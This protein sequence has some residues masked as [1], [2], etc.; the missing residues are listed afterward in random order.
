[1]NAPSST[2]RLPTIR[3]PLFLW[4]MRPLRLPNIVMI[5]VCSMYVI[6]CR[7]PLLPPG[8]RKM[9][10]AVILHSTIIA[11]RLGRFSSRERGFLHAQGFTRDQMWWHT[12]LASSVSAVV[13]CA[14]IALLMM[15]GVRSVVQD[16]LFQ[17]PY[18]PFMASAEYSTS[19]VM[20]L[21][22]IIVLPAV[23]YV[24]IRA[25]QPVGDA[26]AGWMLTSMTLIFAVWGFEMVLAHRATPG[27][28]QN[29]IPACLPAA[30]LY[31]AGCWRLHRTMEVRS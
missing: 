2:R 1:M 19:L 10:L 6:F 15:C 31:V 4:L 5:A 11:A 30:L 25:H 7:E 8:E 26:A 24:W 21:Q 3:W 23:H 14:V 16:Q 22:Y 17:N 20:L 13:T 27:F 29:L 28:L 18:F 12:L 9:L